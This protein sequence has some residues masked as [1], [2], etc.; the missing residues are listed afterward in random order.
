MAKFG[1]VGDAFAENLVRWAEIIR[2]SYADQAIDEIITTRRLEGVCKAFAI[3]NDR[4]EAIKMCV[5]RFDE[6]T[7]TG[8]LDAYSKIDAAVNA[9]AAPAGDAT[10]APQ[11]EYDMAKKYAQSTID[12]GNPLFLM[13]AKY[14]DKDTVKNGG[15]RW[16]SVHKRWTITAKQF[17]SSPTAWNKYEP[18]PTMIG[19]GGMLVAAPENA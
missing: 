7:R 2:A 1:K 11:E 10:A 6:A 16:D 4:M 5:A 19:G 15:A 9:T 13:G 17:Y 18:R 12:N 3:F 14:E 8:M